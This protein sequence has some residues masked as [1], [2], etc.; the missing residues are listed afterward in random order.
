MALT[1]G[2][3][4]TLDLGQEVGHAEPQPPQ[5]LSGVSHP[6]LPVVL[7]KSVTEEPAKPRAGGGGL[8]QAYVPG[9]S[10]SPHWIREG[11]PLVKAWLWSSNERLWRVQVLPSFVSPTCH[12]LGAAMTSPGRWIPSHGGVRAQG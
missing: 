12:Q 7:E 8:F 11:H 2:S 9:C 4:W 5:R 6:S 10:V 3:R 1:L